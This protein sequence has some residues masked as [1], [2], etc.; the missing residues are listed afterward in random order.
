MTLLLFFLLFV[1]A[2]VASMVGQGGGI[3]YTPIQVWLGVGFHQAATT[4]LFLIMVVSLSSS[5]TFRKAHEIDWGLVPVIEFP[6]T[7][8]AFLG[9][10]LSRDISEEALMLLLAGLLTVAALFMIRPHRARQSD[11]R[12]RQGIFIW[13]RVHDGQPYSI[14]LLLALP[15]MAAVGLLT[16]MVGIGGGVLKVPVMNLLFRIPMPF[17]IGSS[18]VMVGITAAGGF[19]GHASV[20]HWDW[21]TSLV[22]AGAVFLAAQIGSRLS[23]KADKARLKRILGWS[24]LVAAALLV[25]LAVRTASASPEPRRLVE[26]DLPGRTLLPC[27][28]HRLELSRG[29][30]Q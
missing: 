8:G 17:A 1:A 19:F 7:L 6:T 16:G 3:Y 25:L 21:R 5:L 11:L 30:L 10:R 15:L 20:G 24:L 4:S 14:N 28:G 2:F 13:R 23:L 26:S 9:G 18:A 27:V 22:A 29:E 12:A